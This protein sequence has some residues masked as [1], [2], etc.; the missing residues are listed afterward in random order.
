MVVWRVEEK[1]A[2][3]LL[4][5]QLSHSSHLQM[6]IVAEV[7]KVEEGVVLGVARR[8]Q[9]R[10]CPLVLVLLIDNNGN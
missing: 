9:P 2:L 8:L 4:A 1:V 10:N 7:W 3:R 6:A 5:A